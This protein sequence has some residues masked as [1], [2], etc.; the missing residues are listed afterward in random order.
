MNFWQKKKIRLRG[1]EPSD[2]DH[3][4]RWNL[5]SERARHLDFVWPPISNSSVHDWVEEQSKQKFEDDAFH[6]V[7]ENQDGD[8]VGSISTYKCDPRYGTFSYGIDIA[9][10]HRRKGYAS[11][12]IQLVMQ[13]YFG[14]L[15]YQKVTVPVHGDN[16]SSIRLHEKLGFQ[17]E[18]THRRMIYT[19]GRYVDVIWFGMTV[20]EFNCVT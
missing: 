4:V 18:G 6:W 1:I 20:E 8:P 13:Y 15:R 16:E 5:N 12:A 17:R 9:P 3:F 19:Q 11:E 14:E 2:A 10:E 7:I